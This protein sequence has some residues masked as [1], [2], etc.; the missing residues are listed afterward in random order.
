ML[1]VSNRNSLWASIV[2]EEIHRCGVRTVVISPGSR[3]TP[4]AIAIAA[5]RN[6]TKDTA[7]PLRIV[8]Q[9]DERSAAF[10]A[11]GL[12]K[13]TRSPVALLC[14]SGTAAANY[15]PAVVEANYSRVPLLVL[16]A[17][18]PPELRECGAPQTIDQIKLYGN[19]VRWFIEV[20]IPDV[21]P[22][23]LR[24]VRS[25]TGRAVH[26]AAGLAEIPAGPV[27][28]NFAFADPLPP[29]PV[30]DDVPDDLPQIAPNAWYGGQ[31]KVPS[32]AS[33]KKEPQQATP[34]NTIVKG[35]IYLPKDLLATLANQMIAHHRGIIIV[36][37]SAELPHQFAAA[38]K[39]LAITTGYP[40]L[41]EATGMDRRDTISHYDTF[42][43][44]PHF[45]RDHAPTLVIRFGAM[46]TSKGYLLW[47]EQHI[48]C[49][50]MV[51]GTT[52]SDPTHGRT[53]AINVDPVLFCQQM[54]EYLTTYGP[55]GWQSPQWQRDFDCANALTE[56]V[57]ADFLREMSGDS[58]ATSRY[59]DLTNTTN[60]DGIADSYHQ[61]QLE[62]GKLFEG[63]VFAELAAWLPE[64]TS[65]YIASSMP[66]RDLDTFFHPQRHL[67][68]LANRGANGIDGTVSSA[69]G[70]A[71]GSDQPLVL[72]C[73]DLAFYHD[74]NGLLAAKQYEINLTIILL[75]NDGGGIFE[76]LPIAEFDEYFT[77]LFATPHGLAFRP[78][79]EAYGCSYV[80]IANWVQFKREVLQS[81]QR[82][83][84]KVL[85]LTTDR[86]FNKNLRRQFT[87]IATEAVDQWYL[88]KD[89]KR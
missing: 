17:D 21:S 78:I 74:L 47:L 52:N 28:L 22:F 13:K 71:W 69:L 31:G 27:H 87:Q 72:V 60:A 73:G 15:F 86:Q 19:M 51:V 7:S 10:F 4:L 49:L 62:A 12:A 58:L 34:Y 8:V 55:M 29:L 24:Y 85:E 46:P 30:P 40:L 65:I 37:V 20:G 11:L 26:V 77:E 89:K 16:T 35:Q 66:I 75:N 68:V 2:A 59:G 32:Y 3:S 36:G 44:A 83:G 53:Q 80:A 79:V 81:L 54:T 48:A 67:P 64:H 84:T 82:P 6:A 18:R 43:K 57:M 70:A 76:M 45:A 88:S 9:L 1:N 61:D 56:G 25:I 14:T 63:K 50:Q 38:V 42:L 23:R 5:T 41:V 39:Q 33:F